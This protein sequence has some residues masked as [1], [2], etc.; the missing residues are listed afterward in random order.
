MVSFLLLSSN[1]A[2]V[3]IVKLFTY[4]LILLSE[5]LCPLEITTSSEAPGAT[6]PTQVD[7]AVQLPVWVDVITDEKDVD[8]EILA[9]IIMKNNRVAFALF[10][11]KEKLL[12]NKFMIFVLIQN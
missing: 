7:P 12:Q 2:P 1:T 10:V 3:L 6:P 9:S 5:T 4:V 11:I 8:T